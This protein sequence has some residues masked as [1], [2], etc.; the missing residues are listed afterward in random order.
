MCEL[1]VRNFVKRTGSLV[2]GMII[3]LSILVLA[4]CSKDK[5]T[6]PVQQTTDNELLYMEL[7]NASDTDSIEVAI[8]DSAEIALDITPGITDSAA[9]SLESEDNYILIPDSALADS[10]AIS[11]QFKR[12]R[13]IHGNDS[14]LSAL[15]FECTPDGQVFSESLIFD[16]YVGYF[17]NNTSSNVVK[18]YLYDPTAK[19]WSHQSTKHKNDPRLRFNIA[20]FSKYAISD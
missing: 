11:I 18:L 19:R 16:I 3:V 9:F 17:N 5:T 4:V 8:T 2:F 15:V 13:F 12:L 7:F 20:H 1:I 10:T 14:T 6:A